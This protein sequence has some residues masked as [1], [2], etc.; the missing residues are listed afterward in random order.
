MR[1]AL[2]VRLG[3]KE[4]L[5]KAIQSLESGSKRPIDAETGDQDETTKKSRP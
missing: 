4:I 5:L 3:E 1:N 2:I